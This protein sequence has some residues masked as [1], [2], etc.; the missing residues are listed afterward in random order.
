MIDQKKG[1]TSKIT[2]T[3]SAI[4]YSKE[5][6]QCTVVLTVDYTMVS[7]WRSSQ[8]FQSWVLATC[9]RIPFVFVVKLLLTFYD[10]SNNT[11]RYRSP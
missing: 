9:K 8:L 10:S 6:T 5:Y 11:K 4:M 1:V 3:G 7:G 2:K